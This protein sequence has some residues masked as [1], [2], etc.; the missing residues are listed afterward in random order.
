M[1]QHEIPKSKAFS[2]WN[3]DRNRHTIQIGG[4]DTDSLVVSAFQLY[5]EDETVT[6]SE[7][8]KNARPY[9]GIPY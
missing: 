4:S 1:W 6:G 5:S 3:L 8:F 2:N 9:K 7:G